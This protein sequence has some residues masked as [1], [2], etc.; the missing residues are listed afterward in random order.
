[1]LK[2]KKAQEAKADRGWE[3]RKDGD[4]KESFT[5]D[6]RKKVVLV[7]GNKQAQLPEKLQSGKLN[8]KAVQA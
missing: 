4:H 8:G 6:M 7:K 1:M 5:E 2:E 3:Q